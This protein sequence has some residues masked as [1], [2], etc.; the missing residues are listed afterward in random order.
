LYVFA[1]PS[2]GQ[3]SCA[4]AAADILSLTGSFSK[5]SLQNIK[6]E[7]AYTIK[8]IDMTDHPAKFEEETKELGRNSR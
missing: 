2:L 5:N 8:A 6:S 7:R 4:D 3:P 1:K